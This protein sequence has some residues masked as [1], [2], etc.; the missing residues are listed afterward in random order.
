MTT[1]HDLVCSKEQSINLANKGC[2]QKTLFA[3]TER[4]DV[5]GTLNVIEE[6]YGGGLAAYTTPELMDLLPKMGKIRMF[7]F[8]LRTGFDTKEIAE[9]LIRK[10]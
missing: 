9:Y 6:N 2:P 4:K 5:Y 1:L 7:F 8:V 10:I 3:W